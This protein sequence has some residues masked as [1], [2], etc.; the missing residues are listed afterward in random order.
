MRRLITGDW[1]DWLSVVC[2]CDLGHPV[3]G[4]GL[5]GARALRRCVFAVG[6]DR[7]RAL[8]GDEAAFG[9]RAALV[10]VELPADL[11]AG[12]GAE[13]AGDL[14]LVLDAPDLQSRGWVLSGFV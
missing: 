11:P 5:R 7:D 3:V 9:R 8:G 2:S 12:V 13:Q 6:G 1:R 4:A 10:V 14:S